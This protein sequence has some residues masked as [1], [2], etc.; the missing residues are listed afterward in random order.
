MTTPPLDAASAFRFALSR[1]EG[2]LA[3][4]SDIYPDDVT[5][6]DVYPPRR[7]QAGQPAGS[8]VGWTTGFWPGM[9]WLAYEHTK[10][11][12]YRRAGEHHLANFA[13]RV[14][15]GIDVDHHDLGFLYTPAC[16]APW[17][18][19]GN[20]DGKKAALQA[21]AQLMTRY[22]PKPGIFQAW[23]RMDD[24][25]QRGRTIV[26]SL[27]NMPLMYW[28]SQ[29]CGDERYRDA[30]YRHTQ[31]L[32]DHFVRPDNTTYHTFY[33]DADSGAPRFGKTAQ[34]AGDQSCWARGQ[35][36]AV[37]GFALAF[38]YTKDMSFLQTAARLSD[39]FIAHLPADKV[40]YWDLSYGDGSGQERDSSAA[41]IAICGMQEI[42]KWLPAGAGK[43]RYAA[44]AGEILASLAAAYT[45]RDVSGANDILRHGVYSKPG[46]AG[47]DEGNL[48]G[49]YFYMEALT[50][51]MRPDWTLY[52]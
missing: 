45:S 44:A 32:R 48:W 21:A 50:R 39:Y 37:Y 46:G 9:I 49:D 28:A 3:L 27:M 41:A 52:W 2:N 33:F 18:L 1:V 42:A 24:P 5:K 10:D 36:W 51:A 30:A 35:A 7:A 47:V 23:G 12:H 34:G 19:T 17:R 22:W 8:N 26:D 43:Q 31:Q 20:E 16:I 40:A 38:A 15:Q 13:R 29:V 25:E 11:A 4:F 6:G 14:T